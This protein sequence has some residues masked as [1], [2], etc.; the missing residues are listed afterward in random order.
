VIRLTVRSFHVSSNGSSGGI[1]FSFGSHPFRHSRGGGEWASRTIPPQSIPRLL[2]CC[3]AMKPD[4]I[5]WCNLAVV[6][7]IR[8]MIQ[9]T[10]TVA[11]HGMG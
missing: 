6:R 7:T 4:S 9:M 5:M 2:R 1:D 10:A 11:D 8:A 3:R